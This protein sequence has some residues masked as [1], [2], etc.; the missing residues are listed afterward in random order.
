[1]KYTTTN[2]GDEIQSLAALRF[3]PRIDDYVDREFLDSFLPA[4][5]QRFKLILNGW[6]MHLPK[7]FPPSQAIDPLLVSMHFCREI[8]SILLNSRDTVAYLREHGPVGCRDLDTMNFL[9]EHNIPAYHSGCLTLTFTE[10]TTLRASREGDYILFVNVPDDIVRYVQG[11]TDKPVYSISKGVSSHLGSLDKLDLAKVY[12]FFY[13]NA[14]AVVTTNLHTAL[15]CLAMNTPVC[16]LEQEH[17]GG[18]FNG[19]ADLVRHCTH[20]EFLGGYY[21]VNNPP[22]NPQDFIAF[23]DT[24]IRTCTEFTGYDS[25]RPTLEDSYRPSAISLLRMLQSNP[26]GAK[27]AVWSLSGKK[28]LKAATV[29]LWHKVFPP[30]ASVVKEYER[31]YWQKYLG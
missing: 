21:D 12:L 25:G 3:I 15:P 10:N 13:H 22:A 26:E 20:S 31:S 29:K 19:L 27:R 5:G 16:L 30:A 7:N 23:R 28:L 18:R 4:S 9:L 24:L 6:Y 14:Y 8:R 17:D 11:M 1:M 2:I